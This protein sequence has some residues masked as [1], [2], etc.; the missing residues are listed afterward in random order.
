MGKPFFLMI[1]TLL[2]SGAA[3]AQS[4]IIVKGSLRDSIDKSP[5]TGARIDLFSSNDT[6]T[7]SAMTDKNGSFEFRNLHA[8]TFRVLINIP[9]YPLMTK[10][11]AIA[12]SSADMGTLLLL[13]Q[14]Q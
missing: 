4:T 9:G 10:I 1:V 3:F 11:W 12:D 13:K 2:L 5:V 14:L 7:A 6:V 8:D